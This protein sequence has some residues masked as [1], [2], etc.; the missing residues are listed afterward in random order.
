MESSHS[1]LR[2]PN[3]S[4]PP[5]ISYEGKSTPDEERQ[6][7]KLVRRNWEFTDYARLVRTSSLSVRLAAIKQA[8][9]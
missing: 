3:D 6:Q 9:T 5:P 7:R 4:P 1:G 8:E 2:L